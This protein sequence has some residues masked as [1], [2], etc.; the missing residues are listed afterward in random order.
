[1]IRN[2]EHLSTWP[3]AYLLWENVYSSPLFILWSVCF[4][5]LLGQG[6]LYVLNVLLDTRFASIFPS[7]Y[8]SFCGNV[9]IMFS[10]A[11]FLTASS[12]IVFT[13][14]PCPNFPLPYCLDTLIPSKTLL[15]SIPPAATSKALLFLYLFILETER[16]WWHQNE[17]V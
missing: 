13:D 9:F 10:L 4:L 15:P 14:P 1:M 2:V 5:L 12:L 16:C 17:A 8:G 3:F 7:F 6:V 11:G